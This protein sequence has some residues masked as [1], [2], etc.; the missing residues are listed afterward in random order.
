MERVTSKLLFFLAIFHSFI[1]L[2]G[3]VPS[4]WLAALRSQYDTNR[5][6]MPSHGTTVNNSNVTVDFVSALSI[7]D[8]VS[9]KLVRLSD[10][11]AIALPPNIS[12]YDAYAQLASLM[13][14]LPAGTVGHDTAEVLAAIK[15][16]IKAVPSNYTARTG[17]TER[18]PGLRVMFVG[19]SMTQ[20]KEG[21]WT[22]RY[23]MW[24]WFRDQGIA[25][26]FVGPYTGTAQPAEPQAPSPP[27]L[28]GTKEPM[29]AVKASGGYAPGA[30]PEFDSHHFAVWGRAA[31]VDK[32]LIREVVAAHPP[33]LMLLM[34]GFN[35]LGWFYSDAAGTLDSMHTIINNA[36]DANPRLKFAVANVPQRSFI[37]GRDD[38]PVSTAIYNS[39]LRAA[40]PK[41]STKQS[42]IHLVELQENY[43]CEPSACAAGYDGLHPNAQGE[44]QIARA[45]TLTLVNDFKIGSSA[46]EVPSDIPSRSLPV[47]SNFKVVSSPGGVTATWDAVYGAHSYDVESRISGVT[48]FSA[49]SV[50][51]NRWDAH[52][53]QDG[54][55]YD[56][57]VRASAGDTIK[58]DWT[59]VLSAKSTPKTAPAPVNVLVGATSTGFDVSWDPPTGPYTDS[60]TQYEILY[61]D[62]DEECAFITS[63]SFLSSPARIKDLVPGHR[64][65]V[66]PI[67]WNAAGGGFPKIVNSVMVGRGTPPPPSSLEIYANDP[68]TI[69][70]TWAASPNAAGYR[71]WSRNVNKP[72]SISQAQ[73]NTVEMTCSDQYLLFPGTW[74][75]EWCVS[76]YNGNAE[77]AKGKCVLAPSPGPSPAQKRCPPPPEWCPAGS[78]PKFPG[79]GSGADPGLSVPMASA[80]APTAKWVFALGFFAFPLAAAGLIALMVFA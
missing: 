47:P 60:I 67:T 3:A 48:Q 58:S 2:S 8:S 33:D 37:G 77:S 32:G 76:A 6:T 20:G 40:L 4:P 43:D 39:L 68:T 35:D 1:S 78:G 55:V 69:E 24:Q 57:R 75:Y 12:N 59:A 23:R 61:W 26:T 66:A 62:K 51:A 38:L 29:G 42:P 63:A 73:N 64:Y 71:L 53:T 50:P 41:W 18:Q 15:A 54:W 13:P 21:D 30:S 25:A 72:G 80:K 27:R 44:F 79:G 22:W 19:D 70:L 10:I 5:T 11:P 52:W 36:R 49:G 7:A 9:S 45:F 14:P 56:V 74:N 31:A 17:L 46:L 65:L 16:S 28:Y 34:L